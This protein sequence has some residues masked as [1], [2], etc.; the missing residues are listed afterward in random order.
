MSNDEIEIVNLF[1]GLALDQTLQLNTNKIEE[2]TAIIEAV[3][4]L[5][6]A[7]NTK[8]IKL[9]TDDIQGS[10]SVSNLPTDPVNNTTLT[11]VKTISDDIKTLTS[12]IKDL[13]VVSNNTLVA[14]NS[15]IVNQDTKTIEGVVAISNTPEVLVDFPPVQTVNVNN[16]TDPLTN[17][18]L[19]AAPIP[20]SL[21][22][23]PLANNASSETTLTD[24]LNKT[25][26]VLT[27]LENSLVKADTDNVSISAGDLRI[28]SAMR[29]IG[30]MSYDGSNNL[31]VV[32]TPSG[33]QTVSISGTPAVTITSGA[34]LA[35]GGL[36]V[37]GSGVILSRLSFYKMLERIQFS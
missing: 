31:R 29:S 18:E 20:V 24:L 12:A 22:T 1:G 8:A 7:I 11:A 21:S 27:K 30:R 13:I 37:Q 33:T 2:Q 16:Q 35:L 5:L 14:M 15:K 23:I 19:R 32:I 3:R 26:A 4:V 34:S 10:V 6:N 9:N 28:L 17:E 25:N 36:S